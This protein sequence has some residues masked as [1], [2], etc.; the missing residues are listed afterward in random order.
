VLGISTPNLTLHKSATIVQKMIG[1]QIQWI[2]LL[3]EFWW[4]SPYSFNNLSI[5][6]ISLAFKT[7]TNL[8]NILIFRKLKLKTIS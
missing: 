8:I 7:E 2:N 1:T 5:A 6:R 4:L 3:V